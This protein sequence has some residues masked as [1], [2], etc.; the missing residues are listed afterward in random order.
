VERLIR[1]G[2]NSWNGFRSAFRTE[3]ALR[4]ELALLV[5]AIPG[6]FIVTGDPWKRILLVGVVLIVVMAELLN[7]AIEKLADYLTREQDAQIGKVK[8]IGSA[9]IGV[10]FV[11]VA[12]TWGVALQEW[13]RG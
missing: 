4:Q 9:A 11:L 10:G 2:L 12:L 13:A 7:T 3:A 6:A 8:D 1:A 5:V